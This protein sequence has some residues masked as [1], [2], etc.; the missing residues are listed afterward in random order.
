MPSFR[1]ACCS[2]WFSACAALRPTAIRSCSRASATASSRRTSGGCSTGCSSRISPISASVTAPNCSRGCRPAPLAANQALSLVVTAIGRD[3]LTLTA[4][5]VVMF[6][7][8]PIMSLAVFVVAPPVVLALRKLV[9]RIK[10]VAFAPM[11]G[12]RAN[13]G[14]I[15]GDHSRHPAGEVVHAG[16]PDARAL[17]RKRRRRAVRTPTRWRASAT[18]PGR[19]SKRWPVS[20]LPS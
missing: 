9:K 1:P 18:A 19:S 17:R 15:A 16:R 7:Q 3:F 5:V 4:L 20:R 10:N 8:D 12:R 2:C 14:D 11:A 13:A 6:V